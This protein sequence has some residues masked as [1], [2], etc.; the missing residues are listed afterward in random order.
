[1]K[2]V[3]N[4]EAKVIVKL[5]NSE[6]W[7]GAEWVVD[8]INLNEL[9]RKLSTAQPAAQAAQSYINLDTYRRSLLTWPIT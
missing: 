2:Q 5:I 1:M 9:K 7:D 3:T 6:Q 8:G 4:E